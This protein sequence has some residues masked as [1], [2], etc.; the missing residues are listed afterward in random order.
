MHKDDPRLVEYHE[1]EIHN[2]I[3]RVYKFKNGFGASVIKH[4]FSYGGKKGLWEL[5]LLDNEGELMYNGDYPDVVGHLNDPQLD[6]ELQKI[7]RY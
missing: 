1:V 2:G 7:A 6:R 5:A 4:D 3:G